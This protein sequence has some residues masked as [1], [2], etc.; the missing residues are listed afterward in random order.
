[1][2]ADEKEDRIV[3]FSTGQTRVLLSKSSITG[4]G[5]NWQHCARQAFIG[6]SFSYESYYQAVRRCWRFGQKRPVH[7][8]IAMADT[9]KAIWDVVSRKADCHDAMKGE[10]RAAM[11]RACKTHIQKSY[12][13]QLPITVPGWMQ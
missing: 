7:V 6:L 2:S 4:F 1:M 13:A 8:H 11:A 9:E 3:A 5:L 10:M 12:D